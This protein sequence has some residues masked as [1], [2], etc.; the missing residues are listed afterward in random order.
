ML[1]GR[2]LCNNCGELI[3]INFSSCDRLHIEY[4]LLSSNLLLTSLCNI[5]GIPDFDR[6]LSRMIIPT[7]IEKSDRKSINISFRVIS[8]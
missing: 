7:K 1:L 3:R 5:E 2:Y 8:K 6:I 4:R